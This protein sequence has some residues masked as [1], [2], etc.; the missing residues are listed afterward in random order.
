[1]AGFDYGVPV[2][3]TRDKD[4]IVHAFLN[5]CKHKGSLLV[6]DCAVHQS[7]LLVCPYHA[8]SYALNGRLVGVPRE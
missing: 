8:W 6:E 2:I 7:N 5:A 4:G 3:L 1:M